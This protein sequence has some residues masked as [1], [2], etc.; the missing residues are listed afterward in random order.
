MGQINVPLIL[1]FVSAFPAGS[2]HAESF[3]DRFS[4]DQVFDL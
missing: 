2:Y 3:F 1:I 4:F